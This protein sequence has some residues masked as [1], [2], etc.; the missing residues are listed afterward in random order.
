MQ[1]YIHTHQ[2]YSQWTCTNFSSLSSCI[3]RSMYVYM[4]TINAKLP[5]VK[6]CCDCCMCMFTALL[7]FGQSCL[8]LQLN[9]FWPFLPG[10]IL[11]PTVE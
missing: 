9:R 4:D 6:R 5:K 7:G 8:L 2:T 10:I 11:H 1:T 3:G